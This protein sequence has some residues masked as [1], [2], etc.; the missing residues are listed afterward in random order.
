MSQIVSGVVKG[1]VIVPD[2]PLPEGRRVEVVVPDGVPADPP[3]EAII[4]DRGR[5]PEIRG[6]RVTVYTILDYLLDAWHPDRIAAFL[7]VTSRQV[8]AA[9]EYIHEHTLDVMREYVKMLERA[10]RGNPPELQAK[11]DAGH[12]RFKAFV[13]RVRSLE[14]ADPEVR[15]QK[16]AEMVR[17]YREAVKQEADDARHNGRQ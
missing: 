5:G 8:E 1:G 10:E 14:E 11:I 7:R 4:H 13:A 9:I 2:A 17:A 15:R 3:D 6:T 12:E 16:V